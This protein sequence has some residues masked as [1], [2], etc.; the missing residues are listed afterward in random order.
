LVRDGA[1]LVVA[2]ALTLYALGRSAPT[3]ARA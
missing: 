1:P 2:A 3:P